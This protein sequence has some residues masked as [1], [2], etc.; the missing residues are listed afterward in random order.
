MRQL[1]WP[2]RGFDTLREGRFRTRYPSRFL[3]YW[4]MRMLLEEMHERHGRP[5]SVLEVG[6]GDGKMPRFLDGP[7]LG[8]G[9]HG[10]PPWIARW[11]GLDV[12]TERDTIR[13]HSY[14]R[15]IEADVE[16]DAALPLQ[17][18][19]AVVLL[20]VLEHLFDP[21]KALT[22]LVGSLRDG[23]AL[24]GGS[25]TMPDAI[26]L[27]HEP[28]LRHRNKALWQDVRAHRHLSVITPGRIR[29]FAKKN[30]LSVDLLSGAFFCR[31]TNFAAENSRLWIRSNLAWGAFLPSLGGELYFSIQKS[32]R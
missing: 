13:R 10:L 19:D 31:W 27:L 17:H 9:R 22:R 12:Q 32:I 8:D 5:L 4:F 25:P 7:Y 18:Y 2:L 28:W 29:R 30:T 26:A 14:S 15:F 20:H 24:M 6:I 11:D 3:R 23:G 21:E 16:T 1:R